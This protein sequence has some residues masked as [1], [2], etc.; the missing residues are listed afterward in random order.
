MYFPHFERTARDDA[1][2]LIIS[3]RSWDCY[4]VDEVRRSQSCFSIASSNTP[5][6][7]SGHGIWP[8]SLTRTPVSH[9]VTGL[10]RRNN[11]ILSQK[12]CPP[13]DIFVIPNQICLPTSRP[14]EAP[15]N[16][17]GFGIN[18]LIKGGDGTMSGRRPTVI[19]ITKQQR[20]CHFD[21]DGIMAD[22]VQL[23]AAI[24]HGEDVH[25]VLFGPGSIGLAFSDFSCVGLPN[26]TTKALTAAPIVVTR[27]EKNTPAELNGVK[28]GDLIVSLNR[29]GLSTE[30]TRDE[31]L[32]LLVASERPMSVGFRHVR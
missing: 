5:L 25:E 21:E 19:M 2:P 22:V 6:P 17:D 16:E 28:A 23:S 27:V 13:G 20:E 4:Q 7:S 31:F 10:T 1:M 9:R 29:I 24:S 3:S 11:G 15:M 8:C 14:F 12:P 32:E 26:Q 18:S 30:T